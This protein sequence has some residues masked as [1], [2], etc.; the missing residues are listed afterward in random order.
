MAYGKSLKKNF[1]SNGGGDIEMP[2]VGEIP[3]V[4][5]D[6][7]ELFSGRDETSRTQTTRD[8]S[9]QV[10]PMVR[11]NNV[12]EY[13]DAATESEE[14]DDVDSDEPDA[15]EE[16]VKVAAP[17]Q[18]KQKTKSADE[19]LRALREARER[20]EWERDALKNQMLEM[21][22]AMQN[23]Y[24]PQ[25]QPRVDQPDPEIDDFNFDIADDALIEGKD[26]KRL[27]QELKKVKTQLKQFGS[28]SRETAVESKIRSNFPDF[29]EV[30]SKQN[31]ERLNHEYPEIA[32]TL[33]DTPDLYNKASAAYSIM[34]KFGIYKD[35][36]YEEDKMKAIK[37]SQKPRPVASVSP[38]Q[39]DSPLSKA[40]AFANGL[41]KDLQKQLLAE[42][43]A[44]RKGN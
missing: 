2:P 26:A 8:D 37:N 36:T 14:S 19:N 1:Y 40:N 10:H 23:Q 41:S 9:S 3:P 33:R 34:K 24:Q 29:N 12:E 5:A 20:A 16:A 11:N 35:M 13:D 39:G 43:A 18:Q 38:Q 17:V 21:Q 22:R 27:V 15:E 32:Q 4:L 7:P 6:T 28:Q 30:V 25:V 31:V 42:M 44:A